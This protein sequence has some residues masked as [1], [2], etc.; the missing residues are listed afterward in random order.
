MLPMEEITRFEFEFFFCLSVCLF[1]FFVVLIWANAFL[2][3]GCGLWACSPFFFLYER[4][5]MLKSGEF[6]FWNTK[7][8][9]FWKH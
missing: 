9:P 2:H 4:D 1:H 5:L 6:F 7:E 3:K 8:I